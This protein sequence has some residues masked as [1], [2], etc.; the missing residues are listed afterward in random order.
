MDM[1]QLKNQV[2]LQAYA[3]EHLARNQKGDFICPGCG[4][5]SGRNGNHTSAFKVYPDA[6]WYCYVEGRGG[7]IY[8]L[9]GIIEKTDDKKDQYR[10]VT[11]WANIPLQEKGNS[12]FKAARSAEKKAA[13]PDYTEGRRREAEKL[14]A[15]RADIRNPEAIAYLAERG[16]TVVDAEACGIGYDAARKRLILPWRGCE[17]YHIDR[18]TDGREPKYIKPKTESVGPQPL[19]NPEAVKHGAFFV[20]EGVMDAI[21]A[22]LC[23]FEAIALGSNKITAENGAAL[24]SAVLAH[25]GGGVAVLMLDNDEEGRKGTAT[26]KEALEKSG[27]AFRIAEPPEQPYKDA[28]EW[29][30]ADEDGLRAFLSREYDKAVLEAETAKETAYEAAMARLR[31]LSTSDVTKAILNLTGFEEPTPTGIDG[32]DA[33]LDGGLRPGLYALGALS[34]MG[35]TTLAVQIA[36]H[37]AESGRDVLFVTIEQS[38]REIVAKSLSRLVRTLHGTGYNVISATEAVSPSRRARWGEAQAKAFEDAVGAY[39]ALIAPRMH[40]MEGTDQPTVEDVR[41]AAAMMASHDGQAPVIVIDYLQLMAPASERH[42]DKQAV[43]RNVMALRQLARD[44]KAPVIVISSLNRSSYSEGVT[45]DSWKESGAVEYG[46]DVLLGLQPRGLRE[47]LE[48]ARDA[49]VKRE[50][51]KEHRRHKAGMER[52]C[53]LIVLKNRNGATPEDGIPLTFKPLSSLFMEG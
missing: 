34:S 44:L 24:A 37:I 2:D 31:V 50:A 28:A 29:R 48:G 33:V 30:E 53:E 15:W 1:E 6:K 21:A 40:I 26:V 22:Q 38:A 39:D 20:V 9:V 35:K 32:L 46:S 41:A 52:E 18:A 19:Y 5:G 17:W 10:L 3:E 36:D 23:G 47:R 13:Q 4:S 12:D 49:R 7:D 25:D 14:Q 43:D 16:L 51:D 45:L 27:I 8:D 42:T 11:E